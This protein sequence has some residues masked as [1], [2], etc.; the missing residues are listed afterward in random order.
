MVALI[1]SLNVLDFV[2]L[3][4]LIVFFV[5][6]IQ[7]GF[8][9]TLAGVVGVLVSLVG[10]FFGTG[11]L[12][13]VVSQFLRRILAQGLASQLS[14]SQETLSQIAGAVVTVLENSVLKSIIFVLCYFVVITVWLYACNY[15]SI[16]NKFHGLQKFDQ[17][18]GGLLG[19]VKG[20]ILL[21]IVLYALSHLGFLPDSMLDGSILVQKATFFVDAVPR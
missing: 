4:V 12:L 3:G 19:I 11:L 17:L 1:H 6:G 2:I 13:P 7:R 14:G 10:A 18:V 20:I 9:R 5:A 16:L 21:S 8:A 15:L